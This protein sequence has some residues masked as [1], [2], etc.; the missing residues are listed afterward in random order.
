MLDLE[1]LAEG[2]GDMKVTTTR[3]ENRHDP[4]RI[5]RSVAS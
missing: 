3:T 1:L 4:A 5:L 2:T